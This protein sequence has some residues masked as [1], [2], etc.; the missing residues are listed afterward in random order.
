MNE[1]F[2][3]LVQSKTLVIDLD[4]SPSCCGVV[5]GERKSFSLNISGEV[6][7]FSADVVAI[8]A[9]RGGS[10]VLLRLVDPENCH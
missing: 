2:Q 4:V 6:F 5:K 10:Q 3:S 8:Q 1:I 9:T 7:D